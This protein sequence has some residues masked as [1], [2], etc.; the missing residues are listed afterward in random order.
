MQTTIAILGIKVAELCEVKQEGIA[1]K[2]RLGCNLMRKFLSSNLLYFPAV[3]EQGGK[4]APGKW[5]WGKQ[6]NKKPQVVQNNQ[7]EE[8]GGTS[9]PA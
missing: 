5:T 7:L 9:N 1:N 4:Q 3:T 8:I 2:A 6:R